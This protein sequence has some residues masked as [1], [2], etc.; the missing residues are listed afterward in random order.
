VCIRLLKEEHTKYNV[1]FFVCDVNNFPEFSVRSNT[2]AVS[3]ISY[4]DDRTA[5][6]LS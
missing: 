6:L 3:L 2:I 4:S 1:D 5:S